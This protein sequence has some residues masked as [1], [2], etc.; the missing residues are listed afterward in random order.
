MIRVWSDA[1][2]AGLLADVRAR[3]EALPRMSEHGD[4][5]RHDA[6]TAVREAAEA[7]GLN[8]E[9]LDGDGQPARVGDIVLI[10]G[11]G[12]RR[13]LV[14]QAHRTKQGWDLL[15]VTSDGETQQV[16]HFRC[17]IVEE[18]SAHADARNDVLV[19]V[20]VQQPGWRH[21]VGMRVPVGGEP[22]EAAIVLD[23]AGEQVPI[24]VEV[25]R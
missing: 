13:W 15:T 20:S 16:P 8:P 18:L 24:A 5:T 7:G 12:S 10:P 9:L 6:Y 4:V 11:M 2:V 14:Q 17:R 22:V 25:T 21:T 1:E 19:R 23:R 3:I